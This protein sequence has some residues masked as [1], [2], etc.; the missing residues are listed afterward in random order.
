MGAEKQDAQDVVL[1]S[2]IIEVGVDVDR[3]SLM[4]I[5]GQPKTTAQYIQVSGRIGRKPDERPGLVVTIYSNRNARDKSHFEHFNEYHQKLYGE[6][7][8]SSA[9]PYSQMAIRRGLNAV[10]I[11]FIRQSFNKKASGEEISP[12]Y[13]EEI[14]PE[15]KKFANR[16]IQRA[17]Y[18][19][20][21]EI[22]FLKKKLINY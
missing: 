14:L 4:T 11:G 3:L 8:S 6:V 15:V 19:D 7:E 5:V 13:L 18:V 22:E 21:N 10:I 2:N 12:S 1:A 9:T 20:D 17:E 16:L